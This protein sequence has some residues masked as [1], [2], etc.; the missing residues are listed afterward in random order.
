M[1]AGFVGLRW[2]CEIDVFS[3]SKHESDA[4]EFGTKGVTFSATKP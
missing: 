4:G 3:D 1:E 2:G